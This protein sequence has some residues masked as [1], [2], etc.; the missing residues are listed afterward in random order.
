[1]LPSTTDGD[2]D[3][4]YGRALTAAQP[5][6]DNG[7]SLL[8]ASRDHRLRRVFRPQQEVQ[9][10]AQLKDV[11]PFYVRGWQG[12]HALAD[13]VYPSKPSRPHAD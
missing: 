8:D 4:R 9:R 7:F 2:L 12:R 5:C 1:M 13:L 11:S 10:L 6:N 3:G